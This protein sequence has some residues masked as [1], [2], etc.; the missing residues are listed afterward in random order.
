MGNDSAVLAEG[1]RKCYGRRARGRHYPAPLRGVA[2]AGLD[3]YVAE[4]SVH[5]LLGPNG[6]GKTTAVRVLTT[7]LRPDAGRARVLG[8]D[9]VADADQLRSR[10]GLAGQYAAVDE[11]LTGAENLEMFGRLYRLPARAARTRAAELLERFDLTGAA[12]RQVRTYSGGM[13]RRLDL[14]ASMIMAPALLFLDEPTSGLDPRSRRQMWEFVE[15]LVQSGTTVLL[16]TQY[17]EEADR[18]AHQVS[19]VDGGRVIAEGTPEDLKSRL[20]GDRL[21][22]EIARGADT[23]TA[24]AALSKIVNTEVSTDVEAWQVSA[25]IQAGAPV[26][27]DVVRGL[28]EMGV[29]IVDIAL[30]RPSLDDV[31]L[32]L[33]GRDTVREA[34]TPAPT[35]APAPVP[36]PAPAGATATATA[37]ELVTV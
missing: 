35:P 19:V 25:P 18:L 2:L 24:A 11:Q 5:A 14:A 26:L 15:N 37:E 8:L 12:G 31:F 10:I 34:P 36:A 27:A 32:T 28:D 17:L 3:L 16:T 9:V 6:A 30:H 13:R 29:K 21:T 22:I 1:L 4:G 20:G 23:A 33:T 7:L